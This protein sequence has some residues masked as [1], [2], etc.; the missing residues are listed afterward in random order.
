MNS[1]RLSSRRP[2]TQVTTRSLPTAWSGSAASA[3][4]ASAHR[5]TRAWAPLRPWRRTS[6]WTPTGPHGT[7]AQKVA[8]ADTRCRSSRATSRVAARNAVAMVVPPNAY[9]TRHASGM[10][11]VN[12]PGRPGTGWGV[13]SRRMAPGGTVVGTGATVAHGTAAVP[14]AGPGA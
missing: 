11:V 7:A 9:M 4:G 12:R 5:R 3:S 13:V 6:T 14:A 2:N 8:S 10:V 1:R